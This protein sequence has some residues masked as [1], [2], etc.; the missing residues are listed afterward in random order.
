MWGSKVRFACS[1]HGV[2][3]APYNTGMRHKVRELQSSMESVEVTRTLCLLVAVAE[4]RSFSA[5]AKALHLTPSAVS[6]AVARVEARLG[7][8][9]VQR[10]T[11]RVSLT[12]LGQIYVE[13][14]RA[15]L[16]ELDRIEREV[17]A[18][19]DA[20][21]GSLRVA[22]PT[23]YGALRAAPLVARF[24]REYPQVDVDL[25]CN[26][27]VV[28]LAGDRVDVA[29]RMIAAPPAE[30]VAR[31]LEPDRRGL[32]ASP[33][34]LERSPRVRDVD[35]LA[36]HAALHYVRYGA[37]TAR[38][39]EWQL[40]AEGAQRRVRSVAVFSSDSV[41]AVHEA[42][43]V[44]LG[45]AELPTYLAD[46]DVKEGVLRELLAGSLPVRRSVFAMYLPS[47]YLPQR[48]RALVAFLEKAIAAERG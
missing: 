6:K 30:V 42:A 17:T 37:R 10:T 16:A 38:S 22:A 41:L 23:I 9:L 32:Y 45:I 7:A 29:L 24:Q 15:V 11:R 26:D 14:G 25:R 19:D 28:D 31:R 33:V 12:D 5:A 1:E 21:R 40:V 44:G 3:P 8:R 34:Y 43:R 39:V 13:R 47:L 35:D 20:V 4:G 36:L 46:R 48:T 18:R 27:D 2:G